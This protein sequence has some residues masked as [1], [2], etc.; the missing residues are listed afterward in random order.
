VR[1]VR[2]IALGSRRGPASEA[3][4]L[5]EDLSPERPKRQGD[6]AAEPDFEMREKGAGRPTKRHR[7]ETQK[8]KSDLEQD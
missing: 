7:R 1:V 4:E 8:L 2:I 6:K 3:V 5:Y